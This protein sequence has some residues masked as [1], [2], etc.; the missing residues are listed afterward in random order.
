MQPVSDASPGQHGERVGQL[1]RSGGPAKDGAGVSGRS[2][3][4][5]SA[6]GGDSVS[7]AEAE[8]ESEASPEAGA[9]RSLPSAEIDELVVWAKLRSY[10]WCAPRCASLCRRP[11]P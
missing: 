8:A 6:V 5:A 10:P 9:D 2:E 4:G 7:A 3:A 11:S 1:E